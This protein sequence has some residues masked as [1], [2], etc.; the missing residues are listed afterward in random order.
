[1]KKL[2]SLI[3]TLVAISS[4]EKDDFCLEETTPK[5][6]IRFLDFTNQTNFKEVTLESINASGLGVYTDG[7]VTALTD[8]IAIPLNY[9]EDET[10]YFIKKENEA[11]EELRISYSRENVF[12]SRSCGFKTNFNNLNTSQLTNNWIQQVQVQNSSVNNEQSAHLYI[13]H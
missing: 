3:F 13:F 4:C 9:L 5:L 7:N 2:L 10:T 12:L 6:I 1:M 11:T 8:S